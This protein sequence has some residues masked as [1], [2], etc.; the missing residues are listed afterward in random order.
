M[1]AA[2]PAKNAT[3]QIV[4]TALAAALTAATPLAIVGTPWYAVILAALGASLGV[5][6]GAEV[7]GQSR[8]RAADATAAREAREPREP[9]A[10]NAREPRDA[11]PPR[12]S[13]PR[14]RAVGNP[15]AVR[16]RW[17]RKE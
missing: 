5:V 16:N 9:P 4:L 8:A 11:P 17:R 13:E 10:T 14:E 6:G 1:S 2:T 15:D 3:W 7:R 12:A